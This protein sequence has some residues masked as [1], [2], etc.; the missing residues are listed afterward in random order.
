MIIRDATVTSFPDGHAFQLE[1]NAYWVTIKCKGKI[2]FQRTPADKEA[3][4]DKAHQ[5]ITSALSALEHAVDEA[6][7]RGLNAAADAADK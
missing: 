5:A 4:G 3:W 6:G 1:T 7:K 2:I